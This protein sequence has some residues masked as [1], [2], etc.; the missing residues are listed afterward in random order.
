[1]WVLAVVALRVVVVV[2]SAVN[3]PVASVIG[4]TGSVHPTGPP[5]EGSRLAAVGAVLCRAALVVCAGLAVGFLSVAVHRVDA[6]A[7]RAG[8]NGQRAA[9]PP[10]PAAHPANVVPAGGNPCNRAGPLPASCHPVKYV[11]PAKPAPPVKHPANVVPAGGNP[12]NRAGPLPAS[13]H[14]VKP[15][16]PVK[17]PA[18]VVPAGGNPCNR[19]GPLPASCHPVRSLPQVT[20]NVS[21][22]VST[23]LNRSVV[24][25]LDS[26]QGRCKQGDAVCAASRNGDPCQLLPLF[27]LPNPATRNRPAVVRPTVVPQVLPGPGIVVTTVP[28]ITLDVGVN[29]NQTLSGQSGAVQQGGSSGGDLKALLAQAAA[30]GARA[31]AAAIVANQLLRK[32][33]QNP[34]ANS[35]VV[36]NA[37]QTQG[38]TAESITNGQGVKPM[39]NPSCVKGVSCTVFDPKKGQKPP[40]NDPNCFMTKAAQLYKIGAAFVHSP[41]DNNPFHYEIRGVKPQDLASLF[42]P[43]GGGSTPAAA[44]AH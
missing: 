37:G 39:V 9:P 38:V 27:C 4:R 33:T 20:G 11:A 32:I 34:P 30:H 13:C 36:R 44:G 41:T 24:T 18:N 8:P 17:H 22:Q 28:G 42:K 19:A 31:A 2:V 25:S 10:P 43:C 5:A 7:Y 6:Y 3:V 12:C 14:P 21:W 35:I 15:A 16:A 40:Q 23:T 1:V 26:T 29:A